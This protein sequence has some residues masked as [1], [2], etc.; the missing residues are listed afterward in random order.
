MSEGRRKFPDSGFRPPPSGLKRWRPFDGLDAANSR[1]N[2]KFVPCGEGRSVSM[3]FDLRQLGRHGGGQR[4]EHLDRTF[5]PSAFETPDEREDAYRVTGRVETR[6]E[7]EC[8]RCLEPYDV[9]V[10]ATLEL[11]YVPAP[12]GN[13]PA[14]GN[15]GHGDE[16]E[17]EVAEDDLTTAFYRNEELDLGELM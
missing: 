6:L 8:S 11:R 13:G 14:Q 12:A 9:P 7:L 15:H 2:R 3:Q 16:V 10:D 4:D 17:R 1:Y 5:E